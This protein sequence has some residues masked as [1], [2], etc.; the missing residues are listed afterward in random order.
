MPIHMKAAHLLAGIVVAGVFASPCLAQQSSPS[1]NDQVTVAEILKNPVDDQ[2]VQ[3]QGHLLRQDTN[4][5]YV[6]SDGTGQ[7]F[8]QI[9]LL[10]F[11]GLSFDAST[12]I[13]LVGEVKTRPE[14]APEI[15]AKSVK[16]TK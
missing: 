14:Q 9:K 10:S 13:E 6:F 8:A 15:E 5:R 1:K 11:A 4:D 3:L 7:I 16:V 2:N 12:D